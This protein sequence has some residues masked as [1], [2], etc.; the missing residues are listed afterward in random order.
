MRQAAT[1][2]DRSARKGSQMAKDEVTKPIDGS[3]APDA[4]PSDEDDAEGHSLGLLIG[5]NA[6]GQANDADARTR[7][8]TYK[9]TDEELPPLS[10]KWPSMRDDKKS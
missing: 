3:D 7:S 9:A 8:R 4:A 6:L 10:K 1:N 2:D 5:I